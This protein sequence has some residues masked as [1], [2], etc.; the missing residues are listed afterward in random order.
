MEKINNQPL[1][2]D[3]EFNGELS[4]GSWL[5]TSR[6]QLRNF[7]EQGMAAEIGTGMD[8]ENGDLYVNQRSYFGSEE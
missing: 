3:G 8:A 4:A 1:E 5:V 6:E 7:R 2:V